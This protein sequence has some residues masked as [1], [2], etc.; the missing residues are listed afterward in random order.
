MHRTWNKAVWWQAPLV[1]LVV[2]AVYLA[3]PMSTS[4][5]SR[6]ALATADSLLRSGDTDLVEFSDLGPVAVRG[7]APQITPIDKSPYP[8]GFGR[9]GG[10]FAAGEMDSLLVTK[11]VQAVLGAG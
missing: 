4:F 6:W 2:L 5:D 7:T 3:S 8:R 10:A 9:D 1:F 11:L